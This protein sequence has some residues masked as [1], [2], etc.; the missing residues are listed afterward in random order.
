MTTARGAA[1]AAAVRLLLALTASCGRDAVLEEPAD[2]TPLPPVSV[3]STLGGVVQLDLPTYDSSG[4]VVEPDVVHVPGGWR[5]FEYWMAYNPYPGG[6]AVFEN[7]SIAASQDGIAWSVPEGLT[8]PV[9]PR[10]SGPI[11]HNSDPDLVYVHALDRMVLFYRAVTRTRNMLFAKS[12]TNGRHWGAEQ[13]VLDAPKHSLISPS[14]VL[15][16]GR[17]PR[18]FYVDAGELG[19]ATHVT[20]VAMRRWMGDLKRDDAL[21]GSGWSGPVRTDLNGPPGYLIW[22]LDVIWVDE[23]REYWAIFPAY[24]AETDCNNTDLFMARSRDAV[25]WQV[26]ADPVLKRGD[27]PWAG[28]TL[29][30]ASLEYDASASRFR[31]WFSARSTRGSWRVGHET[32]PVADVVAGLRGSD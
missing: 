11:I 2:L 16:R 32:F 10:P 19:C 6:N 18:L 8:N 20:S 21:V 3:A 31:V 28:S 12:S 5:G 25:H 29:Y 26:L 15:P 4:D 9:A 23:R 13:L 24:P 22:H 14:V 7:S 27:V 30:R 1:R 17:R